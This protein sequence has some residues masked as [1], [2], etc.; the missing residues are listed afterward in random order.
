MIKI[1]IP[2]YK[3]INAKHLV[4]DYNGT[5]AVDGLVMKDVPELLVKLSAHLNIHV[6]TADTFGTVQKELKELPIIIK[7]L[8]PAKQD[9]QKLN[10]VKNLGLPNVIAIGNGKNDLLMLKKSVLSIGIIQTE[11][12]FSPILNT[13]HV[14][15]T[16]IIDALSL[17]INPKRLSATLRN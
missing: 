4:L 3:I 11:G 6:L 14:I 15:C 10:Y 16:N 9:K 12:A 2:G 7:I 13:T 5:I 17:L 8:E 1:D